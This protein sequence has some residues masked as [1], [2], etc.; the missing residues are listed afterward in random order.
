MEK[1]R[2]HKRKILWARVDVEVA[3]LAEKLAEVKGEGISEY[4]R[5]LIIRDLDSRGV[6]TA[7]LRAAEVKAAAEVKT[8]EEI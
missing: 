2:V 7:R 4:L 1:S 6:F 5:Q 8:K 3:R